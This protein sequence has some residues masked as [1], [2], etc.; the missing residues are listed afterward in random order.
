LIRAAQFFLAFAKTEVA[1]CSVKVNPH[2]GRARRCQA[3]IFVSFIVPRSYRAEPR[4][5]AELP[6]ATKQ[7]KDYAWQLLAR[8][9]CR[10]ALT[11]K[12][13]WICCVAFFG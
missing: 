2:W 13:Y 4:T 8:P 6:D 11:I 3:Q 10:L 12:L 5:S 9:Q 7:T 1:K